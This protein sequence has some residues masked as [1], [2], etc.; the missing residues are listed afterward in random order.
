MS[1]IYG[2][3][4]MAKRP[5]SEKDIA[6][7]KKGLSSKMSQEGFSDDEVNRLKSMFGFEPGT[8]SIGVRQSSMQQAFDKTL[9]Q[10]HPESIHYVFQVTLKGQTR[11]LFLELDISNGGDSWASIPNG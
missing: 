11:G 7:A 1:S 9:A 4:G 10:E 8:V 2:L 3:C 5:T 6:L